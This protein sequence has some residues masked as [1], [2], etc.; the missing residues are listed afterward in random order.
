MILNKK[1]RAELLIVVL[2]GINGISTAVL[3]N[4]VVKYQVLI[5]RCNSS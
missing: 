2:P 1:L 3:R 5:L 4:V